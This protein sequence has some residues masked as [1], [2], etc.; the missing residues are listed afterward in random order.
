MKTH[1]LAKISIIIISLLLCAGCATSVNGEIRPEVIDGII[2]VD[3]SGGIVNLSGQWAFWPNQFVY[4]L[5]DARSFARFERFPAPWSS[6]KDADVERQAYCSYAV[7]I[8]GLDPTVLYAFKFPGYSSAARYYIDGREFYASGVPANNA[9]S[10]RPNWDSVVVPLPSTGYTDVTLVLHLSNFHDRYSASSAPVQF[11]KFETLAVEHSHSRIFMIIPFAAILAM[12]AYFI[13]LF[14]FHREEY[15]SFWLG[16]LGV[17]FA[18][19]II[20]YDEFI[21]K[22]IFPQMDPML[23]FRLGYFSYSLAVACFAG[24][25]RVLYPRYA[26]KAVVYVIGGIS[27]AYALMN[28]L[29]PIS[30]MTDFSIVFQGFSVLV[31]LY[32]M[33]A[34]VRAVLSGMEGSILFLIGFSAFFAIVLRD[35]LIANRLVE[36]VFLAHYGILAIIGIM[37]L[38]IVRHF[39]LAFN[40]V[41]RARDDL[42]KMNASLTRFVPNEFLKFLGKKSIT[43]IYPGDHICKDMCVMFVHLG[44]D[45]PLTGSA[46]RLNMLEIFNNV[47]LRVNPVIQ[48]FGG[49]IDKYL[50]EGVMTLFSDDPRN[51]VRCAMEIGEAIRLYNEERELENLPLI[52]F[53]AGIHRGALMLG[54]IGDSERMDGTV[55][56][57]V[58]NVAS[59]LQQYSLS[60]NIGIAI[61]SDVASW[62]GGDD[63]DFPCSLIPL[64]D[65]RLRGKDKPIAIYEVGE[66]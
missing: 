9:R 6:Y 36:G 40:S 51:T 62:L 35:L 42:S 46:N 57:D 37:S 52:C 13:A 58:V 25:V 20:C 64:G 21:I 49:F 34:I 28:L 63:G 44:L 30:F 54:T 11:A 29:A 45:V 17:V 14:M 61:S 18:L 38:I 8:R 65:V 53:A 41:E 47:L 19:R 10:E 33:Y 3:S 5:V 59:R 56:S 50:P 43:E 12:G 55:I 26:R 2:D 15:A 22:D 23:M 16:L 4:P 39:S 60:E 66:A 27:I 32:V 48:K 7:R 1:R 31:A 24:F